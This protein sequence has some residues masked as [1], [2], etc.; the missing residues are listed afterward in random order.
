[1]HGDRSVPGTD[2]GPSR[3]RG[4]ARLLLVCALLALIGAAAACSRS[5]LLAR[6]AKIL[7]ESRSAEIEVASERWNQGKDKSLSKSLSTLGAWHA[8]IEVFQ[9]CRA[10]R[11][12]PP[13]RDAE[14]RKGFG[15]SVAG[16]AGE[17]EAG[18]RTAIGT[19]LGRLSEYFVELRQYELED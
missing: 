11:A 16:L 19:E 4:Q 6:E 12:I 18:D 15:L 9:F 1:M 14:L 10:I 17:I 2:C 8:T 5:D 3:G 13:K 7:C